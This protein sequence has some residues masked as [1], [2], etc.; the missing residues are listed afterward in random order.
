M[1]EK[2]QQEKTEPASPKRREEAREAGKVAKSVE[3]SSAAL[4]LG[5]LVIFY[6]ASSFMVETAGD[7]MRGFFREMGEVRLDHSTVLTLL[8]AVLWQAV[9]LLGPFF[10][11]SLFVAVA[12]NVA[13]VGFLFA[14]KALKPNFSAV[15]PLQGAKRLFSSQGLVELLKSLVKI[16]LVGWVTWW[17]VREEFF[18]TLPLV[19]QTPPEILSFWGGVTFKIFLRAGL[20][21]I[22]LALLD[23]AYRRWKME[24]DLRMTKQEVKDETKQREGDPQIKGRIRSIQRE[25]ARRRMMAAVPKADVV[26]TNPTHLAVAL[27]YRLEKMH[28]PKVVA[29]GADYLA[30]QIQVIAREHGVPVLRNQKLARSLYESVE[31]DQYIP[32]ELYKAVAE[33]LAYVY[34]LRGKD[35]TA[36]AAP[37]GG[38]RV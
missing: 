14:P 6:F 37:E 3:V 33:V 5:G 7:L 36:A 23:F 35:V 30:E 9:R 25:Q 13:Q 8:Y 16:A 18:N 31:V 1:A 32:V 17:T 34:R 28:A 22:F 20:V 4:L 15:S 2:D 29:K 12:A 11:A 21:W 24:K 26:I 19:H 27:S 38:R 10:L